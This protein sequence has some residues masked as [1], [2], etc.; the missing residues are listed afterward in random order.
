MGKDLQKQWISGTKRLFGTP[1][2]LPRPRRA[3]KPASRTHALKGETARTTAGAIL[4]HYVRVTRSAVPPPDQAASHARQ[5]QQVAFILAAL[6]VEYDRNRDYLFHAFS[7]CNYTQIRYGCDYMTGRV[8][9]PD[10]EAHRTLRPDPTPS[11]HKWQRQQVSRPSKLDKLSNFEGG[12]KVRG[13]EGLC[14]WGTCRSAGFSEY[15]FS[16]DDCT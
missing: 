11:T 7:G 12:R 10:T 9:E 5:A 2:W 14:F 8:P 13:V 6:N 15:L 4:L 1:V 16:S 3:G